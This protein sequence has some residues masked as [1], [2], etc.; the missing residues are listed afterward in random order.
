M[1]LIKNIEIWN[2]QRPRVC[3]FDVLDACYS[4][5]IG[6][7]CTGNTS[8]GNLE[9]SFST[10][11]A[12]FDSWAQAVNQYILASL[13]FYYEVEYIDPSTG[14][15]IISGTDLNLNCNSQENFNKLCAL[16]YGSTGF[17]MM[18]IDFKIKRAQLENSL[19]SSSDPNKKTGVHT[20]T[21]VIPTGPL[22]PTT[23]YTYSIDF[24]NYQSPDYNTYLQYRTSLGIMM[25]Q[26]KKII[27]ATSNSSLTPFEIP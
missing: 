23:N 22:S 25:R 14:N 12:T 5:E 9:D 17:V 7:T 10:A 4:G 13:S 1:G 27:T 21:E 24:T 6:N 16:F 15:I 3:N 8:P 2:N 26:L 20:Y 18:Q 11:R 19:L